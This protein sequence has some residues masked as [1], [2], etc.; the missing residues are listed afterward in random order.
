MFTT[1]KAFI[2]T[3]QHEICT[4]SPEAADSKWR[5]YCSKPQAHHLTVLVEAAGSKRLWASSL[6]RRRSEG[7]SMTELQ[8]LWASSHDDYWQG[9]TETAFIYSSDND[10]QCLAVRSPLGDRRLNRNDCLGKSLNYLDPEIANPRIE[11]IK[12]ALAIRE[13]ITYE[14]SHYWDNL[15]WEFVCEVT[16]LAGFDEVLVTI[17]DKHEW[18]KEYWAKQ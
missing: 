2:N 7:A 4:L 12:E 3:A 13:T 14:Y 17:A 18:Q 16:P 5:S 11:A 1:Q 15:T 8:S 6:N 9:L 10:F